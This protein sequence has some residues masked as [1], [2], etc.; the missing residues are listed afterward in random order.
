MVHMRVLRKEGSVKATLPSVL[1]KRNGNIGDILGTSI[2]IFFFLTIFIISVHFI[3]L[4]DVKR[5]VDALTRQYLL[6]L[7]E[8]GELS[9]SDIAALRESIEKMGF[10][11]YSIRYNETNVKQSYGKKVSMEVLIEASIEEL[12][13]SNLFSLFTDMIP[14]AS[15]LE[16]V[17]KCGT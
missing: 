17:S 14:F 10:S 16:S 12:G 6:V 13:I 4:L 2:C 7:E 9:T 3:K 15:R 5:N 11:T 1:G 8:Q